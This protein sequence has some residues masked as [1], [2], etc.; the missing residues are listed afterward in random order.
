MTVK[1]EKM[2]EKIIAKTKRMTEKIIAKTKKMIGEMTEKKK[3]MI[4]MTIMVI[5][6]VNKREGD[7]FKCITRDSVC[8]FCFFNIEKL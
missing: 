1:T 2:I 4:D 8:I 3:D 7:C 6:A 5:D